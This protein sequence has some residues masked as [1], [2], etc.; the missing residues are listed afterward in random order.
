V[1][2][3]VESQYVVQVYFRWIFFRDLVAGW[4]QV[5]WAANDGNRYLRLADGSGKDELLFVN[6]GHLGY[7]EDWSSDGK[8]ITFHNAGIW[9]MAPDGDRK[10]HPYHE[11]RFTENWNKISPDGQW[12]AYRSDQPGQYEILV[13][14]I[15]P[16]KGRYQISTEGGDWP[17]WRRDGKELFFRQGA[18][19]MAVSTRLTPTSVESGKPQAL[20]ELPAD[21][22]FQVSRDGQ[23]FLVAMPLE[24]EATTA[25]L[26]VDTDWRAGLAK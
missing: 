17:V 24:G 2:C 3:G 16:G 13:E 5:L 19:L 25:L 4:G 12:L 21:I 11:T 8:L 9:M 22:R 20:F 18:K 6:P 10:P 26:T 7:V 1:D 14:S 23:R 15:P